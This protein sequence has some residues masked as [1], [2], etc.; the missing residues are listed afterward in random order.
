NARKVMV[1][2]A[3]LMVKALEPLLGAKLT[4]PAKLAATPVGYEPALIPAKLAADN[5]AMPEGLVV[6]LPTP[7]PFRVKLIDLPLTPELLDE[8]VAGRFVVPPKVPVPATTLSVVAAAD[9]ELLV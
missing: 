4:S 3:M 7:V 8:S 2:L 9:R 5:V 1:W 6:A